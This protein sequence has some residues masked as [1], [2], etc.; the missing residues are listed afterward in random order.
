MRPS[1]KENP[2]V[3]LLSTGRRKTHRRYKI[4]KNSS[5]NKKSYSNNYYNSSRKV[6]NQKKIKSKRRRS[7]N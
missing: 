3:Q 1:I 4:K 5:R 7:M 2:R 6:G